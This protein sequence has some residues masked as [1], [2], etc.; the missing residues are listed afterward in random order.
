MSRPSIWGELC[1][2]DGMSKDSEKNSESVGQR[3]M[4]IR[5]IV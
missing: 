4:V 5:S 1:G 2:N 3:W